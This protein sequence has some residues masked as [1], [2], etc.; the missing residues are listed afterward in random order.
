MGGLQHGQG[1]T[2]TE[3]A[4][5][6]MSFAEFPNIAGSQTATDGGIDAVI[7]FDTAIDAP[8]IDDDAP[9]LQEV[10]AVAS[11]PLVEQEPEAAPSVEGPAL[12]LMETLT[13]AS[14]EITS[15][16]TSS[17]ATTRETTTAGTQENEPA[18]AP[19]TDPSLLTSTY[20]LEVQPGD[21]LAARF[22]LLGVPS[23][24]VASLLGAPHAKKLLS[25]LFTGEVLIVTV[26]PDSSLDKLE[27]HAKTGAVLRIDRGDQGF[28]SE[29]KEPPPPTLKTRVAQG[30]IE[31]SFYNAARDAGLNGSTRRLFSSMLSSSV[32]FGQ[33]RS[34]DR[35]RAL[36]KESTD[37]LG[38]SK[39]RLLADE[40]TSRGKTVQ[41]IRY[42]T[43][44][45]RTGTYTPNGEN[46][47]GRIGFLRYPLKY[48]RISSVYSKRRWHPKLNRVRA[49]LGVD[50]AAPLGTPVKSP[51][52]GRVTFS[53]R[54]T[55]YG[56]VIEIEHG[57]HY[58]TVYA[59]LSRFAR[60]LR[61]GA[62]VRKGQ[63]IAFVGKSGL[64]TGPHLH[65]EFHV[66]GRAVN[67]LSVRLP[68]GYALAASE[69]RKF[70]DYAAQV[71][72]ELDERTH[73]VTVAGN[74]AGTGKL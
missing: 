59:H 3:Y 17:A 10:E 39:Q 23:R 33:L 58:K 25:R 63:I 6:T 48:Q 67:P 74:T 22:E 71:L 1:V 2:I 21:S 72:K 15:T 70:K 73:A 7:E 24:D 47:G 55:G 69:R 8:P 36:F 44:A 62:K 20:Q 28:E 51:G 61:K 27:Y 64:A 5:P 29:L 35:F 9:A 26:N 32:N 54:K 68:S 50:F 60:G 4:I 38:N 12:P 53:G 40:L 30:T 19:V 57:K 18:V 56:R 42:T 43:A 14:S 13:A 41:A 34:G 37:S 66:D 45:G 49:H 31:S 65:Y 11:A 52:P 16:E 46:L